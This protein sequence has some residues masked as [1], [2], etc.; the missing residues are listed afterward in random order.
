[1][2]NKENIKAG[3]DL[4]E[5]II[6]NTTMKRHQIVADTNVLA[7]LFIQGEFSQTVEQAYAKD[8]QWVAPV[9]WRSE[10]RNVLIKCMGKHHLDLDEAV[11]IMQTAELFMHGNEYGIP[12]LD[13]LRLA[14]LGRCTAYD[15]EYVVLARALGVKFVTSDAALLKAF[16]DTAVSPGRFLAGR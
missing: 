3:I 15:A 2:Q 11:Q 10:F 4:R 8:T 12:S 5:G 7:H 16:P 14:S 13:V 1:M 6:Y 9:L